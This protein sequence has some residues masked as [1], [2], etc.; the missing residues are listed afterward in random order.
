MA[1][2]KVK[3]WVGGGEK[4][5]LTDPIGAPTGTIHEIG[6]YEAGGLVGWRGRGRDSDYDDEE[7]DEGGGEGDLGD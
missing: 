4:S 1:V 6:E 7:G 3:A 2:V 5:G